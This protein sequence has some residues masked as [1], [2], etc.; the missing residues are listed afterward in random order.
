MSHRHL[1]HAT[2][3]SDGPA[4]HGFFGIAGDSSLAADTCS[5]G[6]VTWRARGEWPEGF[7]ATMRR[8]APAVRRR[9]KPR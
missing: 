9:R 6:L 3:L 8:G 1:T 2:T 7:L 4:A 5:P